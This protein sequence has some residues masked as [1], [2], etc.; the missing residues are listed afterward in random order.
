MNVEH[1][2]GHNEVGLETEH[3][4]AAAL[5]EKQARVEDGSAQPK[6]ALL[7]PFSPDG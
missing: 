1:R 4:G 3:R 5:R 7:A 2:R 6:A